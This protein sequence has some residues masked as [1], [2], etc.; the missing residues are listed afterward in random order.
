MPI[1]TEIVVRDVAGA[2]VHRSVMEPGAPLILPAGGQL[3][4]TMTPI[5]TPPQARP[6]AWVVEEKADA[7]RFIAQGHRVQQFESARPGMLAPKVWWRVWAKR[8]EVRRVG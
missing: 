5:V 8:I 1:G 3:V 4:I 2:E 6:D 7:D